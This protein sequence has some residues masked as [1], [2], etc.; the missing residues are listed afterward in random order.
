M[1]IINIPQI[2]LFLSILKLSDDDMDRDRNGGHNS[3]YGAN[4][5]SG[6]RTSMGSSGWHGGASTTTESEQHRDLSDSERSEG[7]MD[8]FDVI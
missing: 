7:G 2:V 6:S 5:I 8:L 3:I 4:H 1:P